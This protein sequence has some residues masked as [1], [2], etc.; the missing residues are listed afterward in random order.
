MQGDAIE[1]QDIFEFRQTGFAEG[2]ISGHFTATG[3]IPRFLSRLKEAGIDLRMDL[4][5]PS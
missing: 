2:K 4:F 1:L 3:K 5:T